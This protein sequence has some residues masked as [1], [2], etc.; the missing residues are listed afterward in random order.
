MHDFQR[1]AFKNLDNSHANIATE[2]YKNVL[3]HK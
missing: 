1:Q 3:K 2:I